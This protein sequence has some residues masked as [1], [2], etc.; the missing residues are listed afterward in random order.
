MILSSPPREDLAKSAGKRLEAH[1]GPSPDSPAQAGDVA[2][3]LDPVPIKSVPGNRGR[4][5]LGPTHEARLEFPRARM[6]QPCTLP[7]NP[8][9]VFSQNLSVDCLSAYSGPGFRLHSLTST[10]ERRYQP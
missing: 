10:P 5:A 7:A 1:S 8:S 4:S 2:M 6:G 3:F 9:L